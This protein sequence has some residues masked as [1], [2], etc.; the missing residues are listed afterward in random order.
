MEIKTLIVLTAC[1]FGLSGCD[2]S[3]S[4]EVKRTYPEAFNVE[5]A[6]IQQLL[7]EVDTPDSLN[8]NAY[9]IDIHECPKGFVCFL[10]DRI[11]VSETWPAAD[12]LYI[13]AIEPSQFQIRKRYKISLEV[14]KRVTRKLHDI[15]L[16]GYSLIE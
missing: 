16:L 3:N 11:S 8:I 14:S 13:T 15:R 12:T 7:Y 2:I 9:V 4:D 5:N 1:V 10:P 6:A